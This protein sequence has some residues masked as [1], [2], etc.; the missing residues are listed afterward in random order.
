M[1]K[2]I[3]LSLLSLCCLAILFSYTVAPYHESLKALTVSE[4]QSMID[5]KSKERQELEEEKRR[6]ESVIATTAQEAQTLQSAVRSLDN[7]ISKL[8]NDIKI[9]QT[10][11]GAT[12]YDITRLGI[13]IEETEAS[14]SVGREAVAESLRR[15]Y[16]AG[17]SSLI[18]TVLSNQTLSEAFDGTQSASRFQEELRSHI[19]GLRESKS[20]MEG[21]QKESVTQR[22]MLSEYQ[23]DLRDQQQVVAQN[24]TAK[25]N[26]LEETQSREAEYRAMLNQIIERGRQFEQELFEY[27]TQL[28]YILDPASIP[29][30]RSGVLSWPLDS[31]FITQRFGA[32]VDAKRLYVSGTHN[33]IDLRA[34]MGTPVKAALSGVVSGVG[35]TDDQRGCYSYGRWILIDHG[36]GLSSLYAH[37]SAS[38]VTKG[39]VVA[40]GQVIGMSG[41]QPGTPGAGYSTGPHLHFGLYATEG[42]EVSRYVSSSFCKNV[43]VPLAPPSAYLDP[44]SYLPP[45]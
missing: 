3:S 30:A 26:L 28:Q 9:T 32:T 5:A 1:K 37:L 12:E 4:L 21:R 40:T 16:E 25:K 29:R 23:T 15:L 43:D 42:V 8:N 18:E 35:N 6:L 34:T 44:M 11:I 24:Q 38:R 27:Q 7:T 33:G 2:K 20:I 36:N 22:A 10:K 31:V 19:A 45:L 41:G 13:L 39:Q 17:E 14:I